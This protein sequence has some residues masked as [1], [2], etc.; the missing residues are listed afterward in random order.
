LL[1]DASLI[2]AGGRRYG[3]MGR[4]G[5]G[6]SLFAISYVDLSFA[7]LESTIIINVS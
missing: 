7:N 6:K 3:L 5:C 1:V 2:L 4:N